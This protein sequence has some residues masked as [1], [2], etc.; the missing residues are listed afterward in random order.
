MPYRMRDPAAIAAEW[1]AA[2]TPYAVFLDNNLGSRRDY[3]SQLCRELMPLEKI[4]SAAVSIDVTDDEALVRQMALS[5]CTAVFVG[6][7][8]LSSKNL[9]QAGKKTPLPDDYARRVD[10][11]HRHGI[12]VNGSFVL[13][14][15][16]DGPEVFELTADWVEQARLECATFHILTPY[17]GT[18]LFRRLES[19]GRILHRDWDRY[20]TAHVVFRPL[21]I[22]P[23]EL[24]RGYA[25]C[26]DRLFSAESIWKR[27]PRRSSEIPAY[28][29]MSALYKR[30]NALWPTLIRRRLTGAVWAPFVETARRRHLAFRRRLARTTGA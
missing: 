23:A 24:E 5:G 10:I 21:K 18:P 19:E 22:T 1:R 13:G 3:L 27:R 17:P 29:V 6:F 12:A 14:F 15:D 20:D 8:S 2:G 4:W 16:H 26:Y 7:E 9:E 30:S 11:L 25:A 28:L